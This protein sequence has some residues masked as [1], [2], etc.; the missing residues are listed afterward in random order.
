MLET[1]IVTVFLFFIF[2]FLLDISVNLRRLNNN[3][4]RLIK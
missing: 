2:G 3:V 1:M 4:K